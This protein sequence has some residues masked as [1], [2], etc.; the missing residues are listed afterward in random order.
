[1][2]EATGEGNEFVG[3]SPL[4]EPFGPSVPVLVT[5][6][7]AACWTVAL[8]LNSHHGRG[9]SFC[10]GEDGLAQPQGTSWTQRVFPGIEFTNRSTFDC[11]A[12]ALFVDAALDLGSSQELQCTGTA[13]DLEGTTDHRST[14]TTAA[15]ETVEVAGEA[16]DVV[17]VEQVAQMTGGQLGGEVVTMWF[18]RDSWLPVRIGFDTQVA[19]DTPF[20][21][22]DYRDLGSVVLESLTPRR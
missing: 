11:T 15:L 5:S 2:Y 9:W 16:T 17:R 19:T 20:G 7:G 13:S 21:R 4:D 1:V 10:V 3:F 14:V 6:D 8:E 22:I 18:T 12:P